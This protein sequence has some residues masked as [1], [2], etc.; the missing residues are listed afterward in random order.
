MINDSP[1]VVHCFKTFA[2][3]KNTNNLRSYFMN[4]Q[5]LLTEDYEFYTTPK[6]Q[7]HNPSIKATIS[8]F[9]NIVHAGIHCYLDK[10]DFAKRYLS[11]NDIDSVHTV[12]VTIKK[13]DIIAFGDRND[14]VARKITIDKRDVEVKVH[15]KSTK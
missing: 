2:V 1:D 3:D 11:G 15:R 8:P 12:R 4:T 6:E 7:P 14:I 5:C 9:A 13:E 10:N